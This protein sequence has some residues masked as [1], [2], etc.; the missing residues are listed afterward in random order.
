[1]SMSTP[2]ES[3]TLCVLLWL[4]KEC[5]CRVVE[6]WN[7]LTGTA[8]TV[9]CRLGLEE[10]EIAASLFSSK[11]TGAAAVGRRRTTLLAA[12]DAAAAS[13]RKDMAKGGMGRTYSVSIG[14]MFSR[15]VYAVSYRSR[16][17]QRFPTE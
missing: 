10:R 12:P 17:R 3:M 11:S 14:D 13:R 15:F 9:V 8:T 1:M 7:P 16:N 5:L 2:V 4:K 6:S